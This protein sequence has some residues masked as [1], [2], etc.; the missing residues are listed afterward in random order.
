MSIL[1]GPVHY[2]QRVLARRRLVDAPPDD[3]DASR[4]NGAPEHEDLERIATYARAGYFNM[5]YTFDMFP[6]VGDLPPH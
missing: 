2:A 1:M 6:L 4:S 5:G 3:S